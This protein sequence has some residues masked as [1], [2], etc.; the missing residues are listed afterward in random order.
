MGEPDEMDAELAAMLAEHGVEVKKE[1]QVAAG[2][3]GKG[4]KA[5]WP[6]AE[7]RFMERRKGLTRSREGQR[8]FIKPENA[9]VVVRRLP[10]PGGTTHCILRGDFVL[11][12]LIPYLL[13]EGV[14]CPHLR[15]ATLTMS[16][17][18]AVLLGKLVTGGKVGRLTLVISHYFQQVNKST[19]YQDIREELEGK[20]EF[21]VMRSHAKV[22]VMER[23]H[24][25]D[26][27]GTGRDWLVIEGSA[28]LRSS[29]NLEQMTIF[30]DKE[31]W[32]H[33][34]GWIDHVVANPPPT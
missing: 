16:V 2:V 12:D 4:K 32:D 28:N 30:N 3:E 13:G 6:I 26:A 14:R 20:A 9:L 5:A 23:Q 11:A 25:G 29:D 24:D 10:E 33:H 18:N 21:V 8:Q 27:S 7:N 17:E 15:I 1:G 34:A 31:V 19:I 22:I